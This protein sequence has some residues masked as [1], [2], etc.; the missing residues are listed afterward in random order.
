MQHVRSAGPALDLLLQVSLVS[1]KTAAVHKP[2]GAA[3]S[4]T[5]EEGTSPSSRDLRN[6]SDYRRDGGAAWW[7]T[8]LNGP[9]FICLSKSRLQ[10]AAFYSQTVSM[11]GR[12]ERAHFFFKVNHDN[13]FG[14]L[15]FMGSQRVGQD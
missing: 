14:V 3:F 8:F 7:S 11:E 9:V 1:G 10:P 12:R 2:V 13:G 4:P 6:S 15:R 5:R